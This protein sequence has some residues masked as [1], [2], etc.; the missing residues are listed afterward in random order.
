MYGKNSMT[1]SMYGNDFNARK[2][3]MYRLIVSKKQGKACEILARHGESRKAMGNPRVAKSPGRQ[4]PQD[5]KIPGMAKS[6][7]WLNPREGKIP[8]T[9]KSPG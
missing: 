6:S 2:Y 9:A 1:I 4:N 3:Q 5:C 7:G 8:G